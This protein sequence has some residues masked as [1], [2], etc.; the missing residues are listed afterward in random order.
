MVGFDVGTFEFASE[1]KFLWTMSLSFLVATI[2]VGLFCVVL[3]KPIS[4]ITRIP[5][6]F[7]FAP[8]LT[9]IVWASI[10]YTFWWQDLAI[11]LVM[12]FIGYFAKYF[13]FSRAAILIGYILSGKIEMYVSHTVA[14]YT[15][16]DLVTR[17]YFIA[18]VV[19]ASTIVVMAIRKP[20]RIDYV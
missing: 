18:I 9:A 17:V 1:E 15:L 5:Y 13:K 14:L 16:S 2:A 20:I 19:M 12:T 6:R 4:Y 7:M 3:S 11:L 10:Q 8:I